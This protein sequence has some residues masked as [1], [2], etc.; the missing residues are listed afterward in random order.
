[1]KASN[2]MN[3]MKALKAM[4]S[5]KSAGKG[6]CRPQVPGTS[7]PRTAASSNRAELVGEQ[8]PRPLFSQKCPRECQVCHHS[9]DRPN[10]FVRSVTAVR[11]EDVPELRRELSNLKARS[12][13]LEYEDV[14]RELR[15]LRVRFVGKRPVAEVAAP[16]ADEEATPSRPGARRKAASA[17]RARILKMQGRGLFKPQKLSSHLAKLVGHEELSRTEAVKLVWKYIRDNKLSQGRTITPDAAL[18]LVCNKKSIDI[19]E[20][21]KILSRHLQR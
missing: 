15:D 16:L 18:R 8:P 2:S 1:M 7:S 3:P 21:P 5:I 10:G 20:L 13:P 12:R 19:V 11:M 6:T 9:S 17:D 14:I 4:K